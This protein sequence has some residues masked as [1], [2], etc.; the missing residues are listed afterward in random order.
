MSWTRE[1]IRSELLK[2]FAQHNHTNATLT[3]SS[4]LVGDLGIDSLGVMEILAELEDTFKLTI[5][6]DAL[7][8]VNT[9]ADVARAVEKRLEQDGRLSG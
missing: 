3:E 8:E 1:A 7:R 2:V 5:P 9:V 6:D 4:E